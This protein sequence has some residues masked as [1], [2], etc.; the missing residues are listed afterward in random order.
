MKLWKSPVFYFGIVLAASV[1]ALL[2]APFVI[3]W[4]GYR[5]DLESYG[6][7]LAGRPVIVNGDIAARLFPWPR[8][9]MEGVGI[10]NPPGFAEAEFARASRVVVRM[11]LAGLFKGDIE[12]EGVDIE[13]PVIA[14]E[15][16]VSGAGNWHFR[17]AADLL[18]SDV[19]TRVR[20]D[21]ITLHDGIVRFVDRRRGEVHQLD[22]FNA[23]LAAP[24]L[25]GP[26]RVRSL[27]LYGGHAVEIGV[28]TGLWR[29]GEP[30]RLGLRLA[31]ADGSGLVFSFDGTQGDGTA[32][33][34][35][36][37]EPAS[38]ANGK[39][40]AE[41]QL[42]PLM[43]KSRVAAT[44]DGIAFDGIEIAPR[45]IVQGGALVSG[46]ARLNLGS[47]ISASAD[48]SATMLNLDELAGA[49][50]RALMR[51]GGVLTLAGGLLATLPGDLS[52][53]GAIKI[54]ALTVDGETLDNVTLALDADR[55][56]I[57]LKELSG[58]LPGRSRALFEG[59]FFP[60]KDGAELAGSLAVETGDLR[61]LAQWL[62]PAHKDRVAR[63]WTGSRGRFK[64]QTDLGMTRSRL[65]L[66]KTQF[67]IDGALGTG[68]FSNTA[69]G[70]GAID[71]RAEIEHLDLDSFI[72]DGVTALSARDGDGLGGVIGAVLPHD[73]APDLRFTV[74]AGELVLNGVSAR[75]M[76]LD[77]A[78]GA[79]GLDLRTLAIGSVSGARLEATG[80]ILDTGTGPDGSIGLDITA[81]DPR[82]LLRLLGL[83][84]GGTD[85][86][87]AAE[88][89]Q[90]GIKG[91]V[92][93]KTAAG[94]TET[95]FD[96]EGTAAGLTLS[97]L[98][99]VRHGE[100]G[101]GPGIEVSARIA[102][103]ESG[104]LMRLA[105]MMP[106]AEDALPASFAVTAAG[107]LGA[108][109]RTSLQ[110]QAYGGRFDYTG[111]ISPGDAGFGLD[112]KLALRATALGPLVTAAGMP[113]SEGPGGVLVLDSAVT[114][115]GGG[116][117]L[118]EITGRIGEPRIAGDLTLAPDLRL[119]GNLETG[120][121]KLRD[122]V[123]SSFLAWSG[124]G[125]TLESAFTAGLP[126]GLTGEVWLKPDTLALHEEFVARDAQAA[127]T[128][129]PE[130]IRLVVFGKDAA[131]RA[132]KI[133]IGSRGTDSLRRLDGKITIPADLGRQLRLA[134]GAAVAGGQGE[135][136]LTFTAAGR[137][138]GGALAGLTGSGTYSF[139]GVSLPGLSPAAFLSGIEAARDSAALVA[140][141]DALRS[142]DGLA[143]GDIG[144]LITIDNGEVAFQPFAITTPEAKAEVKVA[145]ELALGEIDAAITLGFP[146]RPELPHMTV[147]Y[148][149][150]PSA[151]ARSEDTAELSTRLG[152]AI[153]Q[154]GVDELERLQRE[155]E[156]L[157][158]EE[159]RMRKEDEARLQAYY[160]QRDELIL[161][162]REIRVHAEMRVLEA[163]R[164]RQ[165]LE[166]E[167]AANAEINKQELKQRQREIRVLRRMARAEK[168]AAGAGEPEPPRP[169]TP[170]PARPS[171]PKKPVTA[172]PVI[173][174]QP[175]GAPVVITPPPSA[176]PSQ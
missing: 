95:G 12:V 162:R 137:S 87:W 110:L 111:Q 113:V 158:A 8:L 4:N 149:G 123:A 27:A 57:R 170:K 174:E 65:R 171:S 157:A 11:S 105:G 172:G 159:E 147:A 163:E 93:V 22:D 52:V 166:A 39:E 92:T 126:F 124:P 103:P 70:R 89:G 69:G 152:V 99:T 80:L 30:L 51:E 165:K 23:S 83:V 97:A 63:I 84:S 119:T 143:A 59:V 115:T 76:V 161:R 14:L 104:R 139:S 45:D 128:A 10:A 154:Q 85:P 3:D 64:M 79:N 142:G 81:E 144:G 34:E 56:A 71:I 29:E 1:L 101:A 155:Q 127:I 54:T 98:G 74:Q 112:G 38:T 49:Q 68:E 117:H 134:G 129:T 120:G 24:T 116:I 118:P 91:N 100:A 82:G 153:M 31:N 72:P 55:N 67:E 5:A 122:L 18:R 40:D 96:I 36:R 21:R 19:L 146:Q 145:A 16:Q 176:S 41:G 13:Q 77:L 62:W 167:R 88:L 169:K 7:K 73:D 173:L 135:I 53:S 48:L 94:R 47:H 133:E 108:G 164:L 78:S 9:T 28:T 121:V 141:F 60:G 90:T 130:E 160:A 25:A 114:V 58:S 43:F 66:S 6:R 20:L 136:A 148:A 109:F 151:L 132:A 138:P 106:V 140:A 33:G 42:R 44:F 168:A 17:P 150:P 156:R 75:D 86:A 26:W 32:E 35:V 125:P 15:R 102:S 46:S 37:A 175:E 50:S 107:S 61:R 131:G 2:I